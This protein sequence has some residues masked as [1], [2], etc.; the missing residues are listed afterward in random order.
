MWSEEV[1]EQN[2][3]K[4]LKT[5]YELFLIYGIHNTTKKMVAE[6]SG[7]SVPSINRYFLSH[8]D[9]VLQVAQYIGKEI[10]T[11]NPYPSSLFAD[12][13]YTGAQLLRMYMESVLC[14]YRKEHR[15]FVLRDEYKVFVYRNCESFELG[16]E[17]L[18]ETLGCRRLIQKIYQLGKKD[19]SFSPEIDPEKEAIYFCESFFGFLSGIALTSAASS[20]EAEGQIRRYIERIMAS[21]KNF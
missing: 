15:I 21:Y 7:I 16:Y 19:G 3:T 11:R 1:K 18:M 2:V 10:R 20:E 4:A 6:A 17:K 9:M 13:K 8:T 14:Q 12:G 5:A